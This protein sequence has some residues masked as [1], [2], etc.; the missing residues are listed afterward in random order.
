MAM[1]LNRGD[2]CRSAY[3][4][5]KSSFTFCL[6]R[7]GQNNGRRIVV[8]THHQ[9]AASADRYD[10]LGSPAGW[11]KPIQRVTCWSMSA[12]RPATALWPSTAR[13][14]RQ[15]ALKVELSQEQQQDLWRLVMRRSATT[16]TAAGRTLISRPIVRCGMRPTPSPTIA[17][18]QSAATLIVAPISLEAHNTAHVLVVNHA[19]MLAD[20]VLKQGDEKAREGYLVRTCGG[21]RGAS[22]RDG[23]GVPSRLRSRAVSSIDTSTG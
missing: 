15:P 7:F 5:G 22:P 13:G 11:R 18:V 10:L 12:R 9:F 2:I 8:A 1:A 3:G 20:V 23:G 16:T 14:A 17:P 19:L 4:V 6:R 21:G